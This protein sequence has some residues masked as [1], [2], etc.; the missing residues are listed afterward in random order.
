MLLKGSSWENDV[1][2]MAYAGCHLREHRCSQQLLSAAISLTWQSSRSAT[3]QASKIPRLLSGSLNISDGVRITSGFLC[4]PHYINERHYIKN[5]RWQ[6][7]PFV[8]S[9]CFWT[10]PSI[11]PPSLTHRQ[12][13]GLGRRLRKK[14]KKSEKFWSSLWGHHLW[15]ITGN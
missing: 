13:E 14:A 11:L 2:A 3:G 10:C 5:C 8:K 1:T 9:W 7:N 12:G 6:L 4:S 15:I